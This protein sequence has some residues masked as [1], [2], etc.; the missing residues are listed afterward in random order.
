MIGGLE[1]LVLVV[2]LGLTQRVG[3]A[4]VLGSAFIVVLA[5]VAIIIVVPFLLISERSLTISIAV[6]LSKL[7]VGSSANKISGSS[8]RA[9]AIAVFCS[10]PPES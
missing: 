8:V 3:A 4:D 9:L 5:R 2:S 10:S 1:L 6:A 7:P